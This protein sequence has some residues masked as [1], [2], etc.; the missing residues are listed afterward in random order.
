VHLVQHEAFQSGE[1]DTGFIGQYAN[2][3]QTPPPLSKARVFLSEQ[4][5][6]NKKGKVVA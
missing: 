3:L 2:D 6:K 1:I 5:K 4:S